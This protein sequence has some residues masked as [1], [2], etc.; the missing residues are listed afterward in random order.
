MSSPPP[1][2]M[3]SAPPAPSIVSAAQAAGDDIGGRAA[4]DIDALRRSKR[5]G[6]E[7]LEIR[8]R[9][10]VADGLVDTSEVDVGGGLQ[11]QR[12][13]AGAAVDREFRAVIGDRV[14]ARAGI[15][16]VGAAAAIDGIVAGTRR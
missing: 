9:H 11:D 1:A 7:V 10:G 8:D 5:A 6:V 4:D 12:I 14:V 3:T 15:D 13:D 2:L 16:D